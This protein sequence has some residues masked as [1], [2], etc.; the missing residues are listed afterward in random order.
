MHEMSIALNIVEIAEKEAK[1]AAVSEFAAIELEGGSLAGIEFSAL[2]FV[3]ES[4]VKDSVLEKAKKRVKKIQ[5]I[6]RC[7]DCTIEFPID[8]VHDPCPNCESFEKEIVRGKELRVKSL[9]TF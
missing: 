9:E 4:A 8:F 6:A 2:D 1:K 3:W 7:R 5:A